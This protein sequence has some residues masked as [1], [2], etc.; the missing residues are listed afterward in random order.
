[1]SNQICLFRLNRGANFN[2]QDERNLCT[3]ELCV[4]NSKNG[5]E[6]TIFLDTNI[7][8]A[9][10]KFMLAEP[11][12]NDRIHL[13]IR[14]IIDILGGLTNVY[15]S[16]GFAFDETG[17]ARKDANIKAFDKFCE[18]YLP[19]FADAYNS[20]PYQ[21]LDENQRYYLINAC[22]SIMA[23]LYIQEKYRKS[24][25]LD[26]FIKYIYLLHSNLHYIDSLIC[27]I[28]QYV[29]LDDEKNYHNYKKIVDNFLKEADFQK[30]DKFRKAALNA[31]YDVVFMRTVIAS[32]F[33]EPEPF[34]SGKIDAWAL[35][36]DM[37]VVELAKLISF[38]KESTPFFY[39]DLTDAGSHEHYFYQCSLHLNSLLLARKQFVNLHINFDPKI[40]LNMAN[41]FMEKIETNSL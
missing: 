33:Q 3:K 37:G 6:T 26:K 21:P 31:A 32:N 15:L 34:K 4:S 1:M 35:I 13:I 14:E 18:I 41:A 7:V 22:A 39:T 16:P 29:F 38:T 8:S 24:E 11:T 30:K 2:I 9:I 28:G 19:G 10:R 5:I 27:Q 36:G 20:T 12:L 17:T 40:A 23:L 25:P